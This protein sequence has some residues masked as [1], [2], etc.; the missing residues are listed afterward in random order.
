MGIRLVCS[1]LNCFRHKFPLDLFFPLLPSASPGSFPVL[2]RPLTVVCSSP[3]LLYG[4]S[5]SRRKS[6]I[7][8][9]KLLQK[10]SLPIICLP[11]P[12]S[13]SFSS[14]FATDG[15][16]LTLCCHARKPLCPFGHSHTRARSITTTH[17]IPQF[18]EPPSFPT[19]SNKT[20]LCSQIAETVVDGIYLITKFITARSFHAFRRPVHVSSSGHKHVL[21]LRSIPTKHV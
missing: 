9:I 11:R 3:T 17:L 1:H 4:C 7:L 21:R 2:P 10:P 6:M 15:L 20:T 5:E 19:P 12:P 14:L 13:R 8:L 16:G 18:L